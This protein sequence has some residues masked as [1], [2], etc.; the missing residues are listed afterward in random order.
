MILF[1][2]VVE[3]TIKQYSF[4]LEK[5]EELKT[6]AIRYCAVKNYVT[7][8]YSGINSIHLLKKYRI[9][10]RNYWM[11]DRQDLI[12]SFKLPARY[13][14]MA[15]DEAIA[16]INSMWS[17]CK[18]R[19][20]VALNKNDHLTDD[21]KHYIRY[22]LKADLIFQKILQKKPFEKTEKMEELKIREKYIH[23]LIC[24]YTRRYKGAI[25]HSY[26]SRSFMIDSAMYRYTS[27]SGG[28][29]EI[30]G[31]ERNKRIFVT[32]KDKNVHSGNLRVVLREDDTLE[33]H[34]VKQIRVEESY[35]QSFELAVDKGYTSLFATDTDK[36]YGE[37]LGEILTKE[38]ERLNDVNKKRN[39]IWAQ[40]KACKEVGEFAK[41][42]RI[43][44]NNFGKVKYNHQKRRFREVTESYINHSIYQMI[45]TEK[46][47][48]IICEELT[49]VAWYKKMCKAQKRKLARWVKGY[50]QERLEYI[51]SLRQIE[52]R[53][54]NPAYTSQIC[55][56]CGRFGT[57]DGKVFRCPQCGSMDADINAAHNIH[58]RDKDSEIT[59][60]TP[61]K[62]VKEIL[63]SRTA[64]L[65]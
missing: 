47:T 1:M 64:Q 42:E 29:I 46:P 39:K 59:L 6:I 12:D 16:N 19:I 2:E 22:V 7:S 53:K 24:R 11:R 60:Y 45:E 26:K 21:E 56:K 58:E 14:K 9:E 30:M 41:A 37:I 49:F 50:M 8:R 57:R 32:L 20:K 36:E 48:I 54:V 44:R 65:V 10:I 63:M 18:N 27:K 15:L 4:P 34:R 33:L 3:K 5:F 23:N 52:I 38:T 31:I 40:I 55:H 28:S 17:N 62:K 25:P 43:K 35:P 51:A 13:W 61:Y